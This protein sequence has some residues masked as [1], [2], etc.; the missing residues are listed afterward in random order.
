LCLEAKYG[1]ARTSLG[2]LGSLGGSGSLGSVE[3][4]YHEYAAASMFGRGV[5]ISDSR[6]H[7]ILSYLLVEAGQTMTIDSLRVTLGE[8]VPTEELSQIIAVVDHDRNGIAHR[9][10]ILELWHRVWV[11]GSGIGD[12]NNM[13]RHRK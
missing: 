8:D 5:H 11:S 13:Q 7:C 1:G 3:L 10:D 6:L 12:E 4:S 9:D 2:I